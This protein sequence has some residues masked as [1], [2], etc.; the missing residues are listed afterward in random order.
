VRQRDELVIELLTTR[1]KGGLDS[2]I[3]Q[4]GSE[5]CSVRA[6]DR[7]PGDPSLSSLQHLP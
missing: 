6:S 2:M 1:G 7:L 3:Y 5:S 4:L